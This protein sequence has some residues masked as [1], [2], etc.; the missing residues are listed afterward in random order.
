MERK[1]PPIAV[2]VA[3]DVAVAVVVAVAFAIA[4]VDTVDAAADSSAAAVV[5]VVPHAFAFDDAYV[6]LYDLIFLVKFHNVS[7]GSF[8]VAV[9]FPEVFSCS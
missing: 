6:A 8:A 5:V 3:A 4:G 9:V 2:S 7:L 1:K